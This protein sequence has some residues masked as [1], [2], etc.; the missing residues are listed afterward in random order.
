MNITSLLLFAKLPER[1]KQRVDKRRETTKND[2][3]RR[4]LELRTFYADGTLG[5]NAA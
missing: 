1:C 3:K 5:S 4:K 2:E